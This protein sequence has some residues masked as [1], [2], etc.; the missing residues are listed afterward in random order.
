MRLC[1]SKYQMCRNTH[2]TD[3][4]Q[5]KCWT[6]ASISM[7]LVSANHWVTLTRRSCYID[8]R[9]STRF[10]FSADWEEN[11]QLT[12]SYLL[13]AIFS[14][15]Y[16]TMNL[17]DTVYCKK[18]AELVRTWLIADLSKCDENNWRDNEFVV[19]L[20]AQINQKSSVFSGTWVLRFRTGFNHN[21][22]ALTP[23]QNPCHLNMSNWIFLGSKCIWS[24]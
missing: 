7:L 12:A 17:V 5:R 19:N 23:N 13:S 24:S 3:L 22:F 1:I 15:C 18:R 16:I 9:F 6:K 4:S 21:Q 20:I 8:F 2:I 11:H 14:S 10:T